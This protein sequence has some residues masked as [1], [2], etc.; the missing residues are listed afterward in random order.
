MTKV[1]RVLAFLVAAL[2]AVQAFTVAW[3]VAGLGIWVDEGN[4]FTSEIF[5]S[6]EMPFTELY[7]MMIHGMSGMMLIPLI[8]LIT[9]IVGLIAKF[10]GSTKYGVAIF[11]LVV[12]QVA[13]GI[14]GHSLALA[15]GLHGLNALILLGVAI[16]A[17][18]RAKDVPVGA[19]GDRPLVNA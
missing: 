2:V 19:E 10:P 6:D 11:L 9:M 15:G 13:L 3:A 4:D 14:F 8:A 7:G 5:E 16:M 1:F 17:G 12:L 18:I